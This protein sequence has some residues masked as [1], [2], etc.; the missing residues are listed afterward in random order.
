MRVEK[1]IRGLVLSSVAL[2]AQ[3][4]EQRGFI[5]ADLV[6]FPLIAPNDSGQAVGSGVFRWDASYK[7]A[8]WIT[9]SGGVEA[10]ADTHRQTERAFRFDLDDRGLL[11][12]AFSLRS[13][14]MTLHKG[15]FTADIGKQFLHWGKTDI[16]NPTDRFA[17]RDYL[18]VVDSEPLGVLG[19]HVNVDFQ[20]TSVDAVWTPRFTPSRMPLIDQRW[21]LLPPGAPPQVENAATI[22]PGGGQYGARIN[23]VG[24]GYE[25]SASVF[26]GYNHLPLLI[27]IE[28]APQTLYV[29]RF[30]PK[31]RTFGT[32]AAIPLPWF[33][34]KTEAAFFESRENSINAPRSDTYLLWVAQLERQVRQWV[35]AA[36]YAGQT[37][38]DHR[39]PIYFDPERGLTRTFFA[40]AVYNLNAP[41]SISIE[42]AI[43]QN[44]QGAWSN[45]EYSRQLADHWRLIGGI[46]VIAGAR[47]D[48]L[49]EYR[50]N[51]FGIL[52]LRYSF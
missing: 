47:N 39:Y 38:F 22:F 50:R 44:G 20:G 21:A 4:F 2:C 18:N 24:H 46:T 12:P 32:D 27:P 6:G 29:Q 36:G 14:Q 42:T 11:R 40:K 37:V 5:Q 13:L 23:H 45:I 31:I 16:I 1:L 10:Q 15:V 25:V 33:T 30:Y 43:R 26:E 28:P 35:L 41:A 7:P 52:K 3:S 17:P 51:S 8:P 49:G 34:I 9:F 19:A 48:F